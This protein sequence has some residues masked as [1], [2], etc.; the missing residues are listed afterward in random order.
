[1][2]F[3]KTVSGSVAESVMLTGSDGSSTSSRCRRS[4]G[5]LFVLVVLSHRGRDRAHEGH[6][7]FASARRRRM[8]PDSDVE[9]DSMLMIEVVGDALDRPR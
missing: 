7:S 4:L 8:D 3:A 5:G 9:E 2:S 6:G 1:M